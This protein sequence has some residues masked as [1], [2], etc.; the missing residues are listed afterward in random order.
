MWLGVPAVASAIQ[1]K[2]AVSAVIVI[3]LSTVSAADC[4][5]FPPP[6]GVETSEARSQVGG[7]RPLGW[8]L[9]QRIQLPQSRLPAVLDAYKL[10][11]QF[12]RHDGPLLHVRRKLHEPR[13]H[14]HLTRE[15]PTRLACGQPPSPQGGGIRK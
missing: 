7:R 4:S 6:C 11:G 2:N 15:T 10:G 12:V 5:L 13:T 1:I 9:A 14:R 8:G 3:A